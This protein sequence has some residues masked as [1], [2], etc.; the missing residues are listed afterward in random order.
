MRYLAIDIG[1]SSGRGMIAEVRQGRIELREVYRFTHELPMVNGRLQTDIL[2]L[3]SETKK[4]IL[5]AKN[6][7][8]LPD[9][10][11]IDTW[12]VDF[13]LLDVR[14]ELLGNP[15]NCRDPK[16]QELQEGIF[17]FMSREEIYGRTGIAFQPFNTLNQLHVLKKL[18]PWVLENADCLLPLPDLLG[19]MLTG[20]KQVDYTNA[21][22]FQMIDARTRTW[23]E[24]ILSAFGYPRRIF[25][26][27]VMPPVYLGRL[28]AQICEELRVP[29]IPVY[30]VA[31]HDTASAVAAMPETDGNYAYI[32]S[33][34]WSLMGFEGD[35]P[36]TTPEM[37]AGNFTNEGGVAGK[38]RVLWNIMGLWI[39]QEC[40]RQ[41]NREQANLSFAD[42]TVAARESTPLQSFIQVD[43]PE[44]LLPGRMVE[45]VQDYCRRT[46]QT[47]PESRGAVT[48][49]IQESLALRY[50]WTLEQLDRI[51]GFRHA[52]LRIVGGGSQDTLL[53]QF[54]ANAIG[55]PVTAGPVEA[56]ALGNAILQALA[57]GEFRDLTEARAAVARSFASETY[58]PREQAAWDD[59]Y[60]RYLRIIKKD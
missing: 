3:F 16:N 56:T 35:R 39:L 10:I 17:D 49:C 21:S 4:A 51:R 59:A 5:A 34:T 8:L 40:R 57:C 47:V 22:T 44:F 30:T 27:P 25:R 7:D 53:N 32:S 55:R 15:Y 11:G 13:G 12:G 19:F 48:R 28:T 1:N 36:Y 38:Y 42:L 20:E 23:D 46:G 24:E 26:D 6:A 29:P 18:R 60:E 52:R 9:G 50:R 37:L 58:L 54:T 41:W 2:Y 31:G 33:G 43:A 14:G 45:K